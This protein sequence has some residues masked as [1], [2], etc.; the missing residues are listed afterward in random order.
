M[1]VNRICKIINAQHQTLRFR[2][3]S[4]VHEDQKEFHGV[5]MLQK[6]KCR[7]LFWEEVDASV[8]MLNLYQIWGEAMDALQRGEC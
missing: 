6:S 3:V 1:G 2:R 7:A 8:S 4:C 5:G